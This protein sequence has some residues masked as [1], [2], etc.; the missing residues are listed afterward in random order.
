MAPGREDRGHQIEQGGDRKQQRPE[1]QVAAELDHSDWRVD[2]CHDLPVVRANQKCYNVEWSRS[3]RWRRMAGR[4]K[5]FGRE[6]KPVVTIEIKAVTGVDGVLH[7]D[8]PTGLPE[9]EIE[10]R[11]VVTPVAANLLDHKAFGKEW[12]KGFFEATAGRWHGELERGEQGAFD[13]RA[14]DE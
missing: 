6:V 1:R 11:L 4:L 2:C 13:R 9:T 8:V 7:L 12:P 10:G 5:L 3:T 14:W